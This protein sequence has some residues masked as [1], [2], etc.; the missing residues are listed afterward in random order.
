MTAFSDMIKH[1]CHVPV[2]IAKTFLVI[3][4]VIFETLWL[5]RKLHKWCYILVCDILVLKKVIENW[6]T[7]FIVYNRDA[8]VF[9][10]DELEKHNIQYLFKSNHLN[11]L[12]AFGISVNYCMA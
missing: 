5:S 1:L 6:A 9:N 3:K 11:S 12:I 2:R 8:T 7:D 10:R 4:I